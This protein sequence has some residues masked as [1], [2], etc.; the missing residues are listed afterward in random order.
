MLVRLSAGAFRES[1]S[2]LTLSFAAVVEHAIPS[3]VHEVT[4]TWQHIEIL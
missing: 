1:G 4:N 2:G 3:N